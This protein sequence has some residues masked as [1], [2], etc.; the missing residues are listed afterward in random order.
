MSGWPPRDFRRD[1]KDVTS[2][3]SSASSIE[4]SSIEEDEGEG[5]DIWFN[6]ILSKALA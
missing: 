1:L 3:A 2:V 5:G 4:S 6:S